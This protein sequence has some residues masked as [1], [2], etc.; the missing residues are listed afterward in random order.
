MSKKWCKYKFS[1]LEIP[2]NN[3]LKR[4]NRK[5]TK[6]EYPTTCLLTCTQVE[7]N[8]IFRAGHETFRGLICSTLHCSSPHKL[9]TVWSRRKQ[10]KDTADWW[11]L[12][13]EEGYERAWSYLWA[14]HWATTPGHRLCRWTHLVQT[15]SL[16]R[17]C[18]SSSSS[19]PLSV[20]P[21][22]QEGVAYREV[23]SPDKL[24]FQVRTCL[25]NHSEKKNLLPTKE[26]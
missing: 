11:V 4:G 26:T 3:I 16:C 21:A 10:W 6:T 1:G 18:R 13:G 15:R 14:L 24:L 12:S 22:R 2:P 19:L 20:W 5:I 17:P 9:S 25:H 7:K 8:L 23:G